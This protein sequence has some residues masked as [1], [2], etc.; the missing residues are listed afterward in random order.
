MGTV[1]VAYQEAKR[2]SLCFPFAS[3][4]PEKPTVIPSVTSMEASGKNPKE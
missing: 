3:H 1:P 2:T 4:C